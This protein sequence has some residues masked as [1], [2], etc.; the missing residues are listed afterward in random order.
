VA[1]WQFEVFVVP[2]GGDRPRLVGDGWAIPSMNSGARSRL[3]GEL[4][5][6][7][8]KPSEVAGTLVFGA[9]NGDRVDLLAADD[10][11]EL[12]ARIDARKLSAQFVEFICGLA[13]N[14]GC[15]FFSPESGAMLQPS[16][17]DLESAL[18]ASRSARFCED[19]R[20]FLTR[21][22]DAG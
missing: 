1:I 9:E 11:C 10:Y 16:R 8:G 3:E 20:G 17:A 6:E 13:R 5:N 4:Q 7:L 2:H 21:L 19:P 22:G 18:A 12:A 15:Y 14:E